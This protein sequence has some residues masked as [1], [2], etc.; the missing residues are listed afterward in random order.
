MRENGI[1]CTV[2]MKK[3]QSYKGEVG[4]IAPNLLERNFAAVMPFE[5]LVTDITEFKV[6]G[7][8]LYLST[9]IDLYSSDVVYY[10]IY[11]SPVL[12]MVTEMLEGAFKK[13]PLNNNTIIHSDQGWHYQH[14][15]YQNMLKENGFVQSMSRKG[16]CYDNAVAENFF[17]IL[18]CEMFYRKK[19]IS[20]E[21][22]KTDIIEYID[23][24]N[25]K[26]IKTKFKGLTPTEYKNKYLNA[27]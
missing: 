1:S 12:L 17:S 5:K 15:Q 10:T 19:Y 24:Y 25:N 8:K 3:Y 20:I 6:R 2:R 22:L 16:N 26:R 14:E 23:Y 7:I 9:L 21:E 18:K 27:A 4:K 11:E 13:I